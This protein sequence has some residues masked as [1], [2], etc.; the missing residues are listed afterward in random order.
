MWSPPTSA[1]ARRILDPGTLV[2]Y[3]NH[4]STDQ[5]AG[6]GRSAKRGIGR[7]FMAA[8]LE[9][10]FEPSKKTGGR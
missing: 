2:V 10:S 1:I 3:A 8:Q 9:R 7:K 5:V 4:T 6:F